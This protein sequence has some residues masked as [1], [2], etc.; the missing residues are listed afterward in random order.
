MSNKDLLKEY[1]LMALAN[2]IEATTGKKIEATEKGILMNIDGLYRT[3]TNFDQEFKYIPLNIKKVLL[4]VLF[5]DRK[6]QYKSFT[7][8]N[9]FYYAECK[10]WLD[11]KDVDE[12]G[13]PI[14]PDAIGFHKEH[15]STIYKDI[16][17]NDIDVVKGIDMLCRSKAF[18]KAIAEAGICMD[19]KED[20]VSD[21]TDTSTCKVSGVEDAN[22][23]Q[24]FAPPVPLD[25]QEENPVNELVEKET[26]T[27]EN[28]TEEKP[29]S[30][31]GR[32]KKTKN[33]EESVADE[34]E[35][36]DGNYNNSEYTEQKPTTLPENHVSDKELSSDSD[37]IGALPFSLD[38]DE[39]ESSE[40][41]VEVTKTVSE[42]NA[43]LFDATS[44]KVPPV[45]QAESLPF[46]FDQEM[47]PLPDFMDNGS[48]SMSLDEAFTK[49]VDID[50]NYKGQTFAEV[51][52]KCK[53][54]IPYLYNH[55][56]GN[57]DALM[58]IINSDEILKANF[59]T[60]FQS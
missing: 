54:A 27:E 57:K 37:M 6:Y 23:V 30:K 39:E 26:A 10:L 43:P 19:L 20:D 44:E 11:G 49:I 8:T 47:L 15:P 32:P 60:L 56:C 59:E 1:N 42:M 29:K 35:T 40:S 34:K 17:T 21:I 31:R 28:Q 38:D 12:N 13:N 55:G 45:E 48:S 9:G 3:G 4:L 22:K 5:P 50:G 58:V 51:Y 2:I 46:E 16:N 18:A 33:T 25:E 53:K 36:T 24:P 14:L 7:D 41:T 52:S